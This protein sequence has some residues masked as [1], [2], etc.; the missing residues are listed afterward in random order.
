MSNIMAEHPKIES[1]ASIRFIILGI[2][3]DLG[4]PQ[5]KGPKLVPL[6]KGEGELQ[7]HSK[8]IIEGEQGL[9]STTGARASLR[10]LVPKPIK[11]M[12]FGSQIPQILGT[13]TLG[14]G[15]V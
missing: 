11:T 1:M 3:E 14:V 2:F 6:I 8:G 12:V 10:S 7:V 13:W 15:L 4:K 9:L 5:L